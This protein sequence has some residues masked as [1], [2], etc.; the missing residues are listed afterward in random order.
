MVFGLFLAALTG[1]EDMNSVNQEYLDR[2]ETSYIARIDSATSVA[3]LNKVWLKWWLTGDPRIDTTEIRWV[4]GIETKIVKYAVN[5]AQDDLLAMETVLENIPEGNYTFEFRNLDGKGN[6]SVSVS[7]AVDV[8][9]DRYKASFRNRP[10]AVA[11]K[12]GNGYTLVWGAS[13]CIYSEL[14]YRTVSGNTVSLRLD[15][16][17]EELTP[18]MVLYDY[19][20]AGIVQKTYYQ[21]ETPIFREVIEAAEETF[22]DF[23]DV[24]VTL[25]ATPAVITVSSGLFDLGGEGVGFHDSND[26]HDPGSGGASYRPNLGDFGSAAMDIEGDG[27]NI[28]YSNAGEWLQYTVDVKDEGYYDIDWYISVNSGSGATC[29]VEVDG[30][31]FDTYQLLNNS[32]WSD[33]R[34]YCERNGVVP[35]IHYFT[36][37]KHTVRFQWDSGGFNFNGLKFRKVDPA[38]YVYPSSRL[39][40]TADSRDGYHSWS[41]GGGGQPELTLDGNIATGWHSRVGSSLPQCLVVDMQQSLPVYRIVIAPATREDWCY[42]NDIEIYLSNEPITPDVPQPSWGEP[43]A[44]VKYPGPRGVS[45][46]VE[47]PAPVSAQYMAIVFTSST[48]GNTYINLMELEVYLKK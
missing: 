39:G 22:N 3:G 4:E 2:G 42:L 5:R 30:T 10:I 1:C 36:R 38:N 12:F 23:N 34:Y 13:D 14:S 16:D 31:V 44:K 9:G 41:D 46:T 17:S 37:G 47:L 11:T 29:H 45:F 8:P 24:S 40:W 19:D 15:P 26:S 25:A 27:G 32:N 6:R 18:R 20:G 28:G 35:P 21:Y 33:W 48:S 7:L 43:A